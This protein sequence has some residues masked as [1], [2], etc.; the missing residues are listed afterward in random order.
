LELMVDVPLAWI[1]AVSKT[2]FRGWN[3]RVIAV[4]PSHD[5][6]DSRS[7]GVAVPRDG[8]PRGQANGSRN[9]DDARGPDRE[10]PIVVNPRDSGRDTIATIPGRREPNADRR[11]TPIDR[12]ATPADSRSTTSDHPAYRPTYAPTYEATPRSRQPNAG[13]ETRGGAGDRRPGYYQRQPGN[14]GQRPSGDNAGRPERRGQPREV[15]PA[16]PSRP[17]PSSAPSNGPAPS[18]GV[19]ATPRDSG[20]GNRDSGGGN[21][22]GGGAHARAPHSE[23]GSSS[24]TAVRRPR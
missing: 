21:R 14:D 10:R 4:G 24:G 1:N 11:G 20:G 9:R 15:G 16:A 23:G 3:G 18:A 12:V 6:R 17:A 5:N 2:K 13:E 7:G 22:D 19:R 8:D